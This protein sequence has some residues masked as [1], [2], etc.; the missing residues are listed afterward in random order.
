MYKL[1]IGAHD[2]IDLKDRYEP[3]IDE[4]KRYDWLGSRGKRRGMF[5]ESELVRLLS[6]H[7]KHSSLKKKRWSLYFF[8]RQSTI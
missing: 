5:E 3:K 7:L 6:V 2:G 4:V 8:F 1:G